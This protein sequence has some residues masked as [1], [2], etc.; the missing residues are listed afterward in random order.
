VQTCPGGLLDE[1]RVDNFEIPSASIDKSCKC[2]RIDPV[3]FE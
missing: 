1:K 2:R 3:D